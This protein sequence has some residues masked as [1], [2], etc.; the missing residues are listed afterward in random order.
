MKNLISYLPLLLCFSLSAQKE[1]PR[2]DSIEVNDKIFY[3]EIDNRLI[4]IYLKHYKTSEEK[5][6]YSVTGW[7]YFN[8][9]KNK[10]L[11]AGVS[12]D[13]AKLVLFNFDNSILTN[14]L[15]DFQ[16]DFFWA[17]LHED[18]ETHFHSYKEKIM[19]SNESSYWSNK[20]NS[21]PIYL[22]DDDLKIKKSLA[23]LRLNQKEAIKISPLYID[24]KAYNNQK[25]I[26]EYLYEGIGSGQCGTGVERGFSI[27]E[28]DNSYN[29]L[30]SEMFLF[31]S[32]AQSINTTEEIINKDISVYICE[33]N[34]S[35][36][37]KSFYVD[38]NKIEI[39][40]TN[41]IDF[42][43]TEWLTSLSLDKI[44]QLLIEKD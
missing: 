41:T 22:Y 24:I 25:Y 36:R 44:R 20:E 32:C 38:T 17:N 6:I 11:L 1:Y 34:S 37:C 14:Q 26:L 29:L 35:E 40:W 21:L 9:N 4:T 18:L 13:N 15:I 3:G 10:K 28:F 2:I 7:Y 31:E 19:I 8:E 43:E 12:V 23:Y 42:E 39:K 27:L 33:N 30:N 5:N 16:F